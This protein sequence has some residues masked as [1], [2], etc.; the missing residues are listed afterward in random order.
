LWDIAALQGDELAM[1]RESDWCKGNPMESWLAHLQAAKRLSRGQL[2]K[3][4]AL[5][6]RSRSLAKAHGMT[7]L[8]AEVELDEAQFEEDIG[9]GDLA[10]FLVGEALHLEPG[11]VNIQSNAALVLA[12]ARDVARTH[13]LLD[14]LNRRKDV[15]QLHRSTTIAI[16][17]AALALDLHDPAHAVRD[18]RAAIPFD[19]GTSADGVS[20]YYRGLAYLELKVSRFDTHTSPVIRR[21]ARRS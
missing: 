1:L 14:E 17:K 8:V 3:S 18:L 15:D 6:E 2:Q 4:R 19:L 20:L 10:R 5:F 13:D 9:V 7:E 12:R 16:A 21:V 11:S